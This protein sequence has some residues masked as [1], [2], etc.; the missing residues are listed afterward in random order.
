[1]DDREERR[2]LTEAAG[3][4][5]RVPHLW[6]VAIHRRFV[7]RPPHKPMSAARNDEGKRR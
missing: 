2:F 6:S 5:K 7:A 1:M 3:D 4:V